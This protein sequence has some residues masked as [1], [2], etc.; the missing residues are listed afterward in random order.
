MRSWARP[1][2]ELRTSLKTSL[3][4][5]NL[6]KNLIKN[7]DIGQDFIEILIEILNEDFFSLESQRES[8]WGLIQDLIEILI[9]EH[10]IEILNERNEKNLKG[11][12]TSQINH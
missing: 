2:W 11:M 7:Q 12:N 6:I 8:Q 10:L 9:L 4:I 3:R 5:E 1:H